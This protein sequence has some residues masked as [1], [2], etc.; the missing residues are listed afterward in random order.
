MKRGKITSTG[1][2]EMAVKHRAENKRAR[3]WNNIVNRWGLRDWRIRRVD[4]V[5]S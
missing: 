4:F 5:K 3:D 2:A 1:I